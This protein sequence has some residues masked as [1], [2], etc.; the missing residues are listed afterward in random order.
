MS[1]P[2]QYSW[3]LNEPG[4][5]MIL[6]GLK[7]VGIREVPGKGSNPMIL[8][9]ANEVNADEIYKD[10]D[11]AWCGLAHAYVCL[12]AGKPYLTGWDMLRALKWATWGVKADSAVL[13]DTL[14]FK[15]PGGGHVGLY[16]GE[17]SQ[18]YHVLGGNQS[19]SYGF[20]RIAKGRCIAIRRP[21]YTNPPANLRK[22]ILQSTGAVS[23][24]EA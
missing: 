24:N 4:P 21:A 7:L 8:Q 1:I 16:V 10:D 12:K 22:I 20:T 19:N 17:D 14:V 23:T 18:T 13:G 2:K 11:T 3:L 9:M 6:E 15:R 5:K